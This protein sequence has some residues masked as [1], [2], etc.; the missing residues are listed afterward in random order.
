MPGY[1]YLGPGTH[2]LTNIDM[3]KRP[4]NIIDNFALE[5]DIDYLDPNV[6]NRDA[7]NKMVHKLLES[8]HPV[9]ATATKLAFAIK[10]L[11]GYNPIKNVNASEYARQQVEKKGWG[12]GY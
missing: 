5:H 8:H 1:N 4:I 11:F 2:V 7:D 10:D 9:L 6:S 3:D 12:S